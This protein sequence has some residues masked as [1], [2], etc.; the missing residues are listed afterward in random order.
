MEKIIYKE[1]CYQIIGKC[2]EVHKQLGAGFLEIVYKDALEFEFKKNNIS[3]SREKNMKYIIK[4][5]YYH[6]NSMQI[7]W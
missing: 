3:Y 7:L 1:E 6:I 2:F 5:L 4:I